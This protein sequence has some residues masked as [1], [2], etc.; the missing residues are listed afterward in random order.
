MAGIQKMA[1]NFYFNEAELKPYVREFLE[2]LY[3][4][5]IPMVIATS[6]QRDFIR[7]ALSRNNACHYF[8]EVF[9]CAEI[10][11]NKTFPD[12]YLMAAEYLNLKPEEIWVFEDAYHALKTAK[13]AGFRVVAVY[14]LSNESFLEGTVREA[15][16]YMDDLR[17]IDLF[18]G[19]GCGNESIP[20]G[21]DLITTSRFQNSTK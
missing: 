18:L 13:D 15:D 6:S 1:G 12:V 21:N 10:G 11:R 7:H 19:A 20:A 17:E 16:L 9:S 5:N 3:L 2:A 14:D 4:R 8:Q